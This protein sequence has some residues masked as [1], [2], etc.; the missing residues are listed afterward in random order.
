MGK[1]IDYYCA[2]NYFNLKAIVDK[3]LK[4][5]FGWLPQK[6]YD[7]FYSIAGQVVWDCE[8]RFDETKGVKFET[9]LINCLNRKFKSRITY[10]NRKKRGGGIPIMSLDALIDDNDNCLMNLIASNSS[11]ETHIYSDKM[12]L[13]LSKLSTLQKKVLFALASNHTHEDIKKMFNITSKEYSDIYETIRSYR[14]VSL[15]Y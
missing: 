12:N 7:E 5:K 1:Y 10:M 14:N 9:L 15:L 13:Y 6:E 2:D 8:K 3:I 4:I 11:T